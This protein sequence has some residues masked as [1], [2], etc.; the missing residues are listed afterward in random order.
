MQHNK[1]ILLIG[2]ME[3]ESAWLTQQ[4]N[5]PQITEIGTYSFTKGMIDDYP[6]V[7]CRCYIGVVNS[8]TAAALAIRQFDPLCVI[9]QGTAGAHDPALHQGDIVLGERTVNIGRWFSPHRDIGEGSDVFLWEHHGSE[10]PSTSPE[11]LAYLNSDSRILDIASAVPNPAGRVVRGT[12]GAA[13]IWNRDLE[14]LDRLHRKLGTSCEEME[15]Y[16]VMQVCA[17]MGV[18]NADIRIISNSE[19]HPEEIFDEA[20]GEDCQ[21]FVLEVT[22]RLIANDRESLSET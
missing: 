7:V 4:L 14:M 10:L 19:W 11:E 17:R 18:P 8:A 2:P 13:D 9:L 6:V 15:G 20:Y 16:G 3:S 22:R 1:P 5:D 21:R 12:I